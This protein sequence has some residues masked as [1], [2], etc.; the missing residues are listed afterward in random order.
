MLSVPAL[1]VTNKH[2]T[3]EFEQLFREHSRLVYRTAFGITGNAEDAEDIVQ[4][5]FARLLR[6]PWAQNLRDNPR[7]YL[8]R[9]AVN[10]SLSSIR[11]RRRSMHTVDLDTVETAAPIA[12][13]GDSDLREAL[14]SALQTMAGSD[15]DAVEILILRY[16]HN[17]S[18]AEIAKLFGK[19]RG[20][21]ALRL[22]RARARL[23]KI[24]RS[25]PGEKR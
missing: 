18:D 13:T 24:L 12:E 14:L 7:A 9:A 25:F 23:K 17:H 10:A 4:T 15:A 21:I 5:I 3:A 8:Y 1:E 2:L 16:F 6:R 19:S 20:A 11:S 22:Y